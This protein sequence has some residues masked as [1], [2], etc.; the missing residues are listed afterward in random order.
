MRGEIEC[1]SFDVSGPKLD[2]KE[3]SYDLTDQKI[4]Q[5]GESHY[6]T[7]R[8]LDKKEEESKPAR[9]IKKRLCDKTEQKEPPKKRRRGK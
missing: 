9:S 8:N 4:D 2:Q 5:K 3:E 7:E 6:L 1:C